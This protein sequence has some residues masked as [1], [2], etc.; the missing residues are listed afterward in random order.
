MLRPSAGAVAGWPLFG[1]VGV[2]SRL[3]EGKELLRPYW[4]AFCK[5]SDQNEVEVRGA[6]L[7][8]TL[9]CI[10][11]RS[12]SLLS[13]VLFSSVM[14]IQNLIARARKISSTIN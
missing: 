1:G 7:T 11:G 14:C 4:F 3:G 5:L 9:S 12:T 2:G 10:L 6:V 13:F 8:F